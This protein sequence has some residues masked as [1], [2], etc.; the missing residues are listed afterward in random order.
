M[1]L[2]ASILAATNTPVPPEAHLEGMNI[3]PI[4][5]ARSPVVDRTLFWRI[6]TPARQQRAV[7]SGDWKLLIDADDLLLYNLR[8]DIGER[9]DLAMQRPDLVRKLQPLISQWEKEVDTEAKRRP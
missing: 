9:Q 1:D 5:E 4:L 7:R 6:N 2:T 3:L 8:T